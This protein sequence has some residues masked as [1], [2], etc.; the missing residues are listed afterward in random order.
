VRTGRFAA[1][2]FRSKII[3]WSL[4]LSYPRFLPELGFIPE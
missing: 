1:N 4:A 2:F 3:S